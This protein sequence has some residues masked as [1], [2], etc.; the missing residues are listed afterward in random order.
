MDVLK[1]L[2]ESKKFL[3]A[4][5]ALALAVMWGLLPALQ[6]AIDIN[7]ILAPLIAYILAQGAADF[8]KAAA[9]EAQ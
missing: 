6:A 7:S 2:L 1:S 5:F 4:M 9:S 8:G 3:V